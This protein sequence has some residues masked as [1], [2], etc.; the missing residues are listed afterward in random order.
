MSAPN[1]RR[2]VL[3]SLLANDRPT[4]E[5]RAAL[6][7][8]EWDCPE[9]LASL[10]RDHV[11]NILKKFLAEELTAEAVEDWADLVESREDINYTDDHVLNAIFVLA[12]PLING[13]L[14]NQ[15]AQHLVSEILD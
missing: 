6:A 1:L 13:Q 7:Q 3:T 11:L 8:F 10:T 5:L 4:N 9:P 15:L 14:D 2:T 12:N